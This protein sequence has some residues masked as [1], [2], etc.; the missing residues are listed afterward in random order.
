MPRPFDLET[1]VQIA[2]KVGNLHFKFGHA[3]PLGSRIIRY[4]RHGRTDGRTKAT[5]IAPFPAVG[6]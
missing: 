6:A 5:Y 4:V 3:T 2:S 1:G